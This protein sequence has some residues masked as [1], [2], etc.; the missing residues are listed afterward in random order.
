[1]YICIGV[2]RYVSVCDLDGF[3]CL[4]MYLVWNCLHVANICIIYGNPETITARNVIEYCSEA[5]LTY[6]IEKHLHEYF[7]NIINRLHDSDKTT[8]NDF[9]YA[10][11][12]CTSI[13][14]A[15]ASTVSFIEPEVYDDDIWDSVSSPIVSHE[16]RTLMEPY[17]L[18][19]SPRAYLITS[20]TIHDAQDT[21][22]V[23]LFDRENIVEIDEDDSSKLYGNN[24]NYLHKLESP[25]TI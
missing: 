15:T 9:E 22:D 11:N 4:C 21:Y 7:L 13:M 16:D 3:V 8:I 5:D 18:P 20:S 10:I 17:P 1:M 2:C 19:L 12:K 6:M 23:P 24:I 25:I 14:N